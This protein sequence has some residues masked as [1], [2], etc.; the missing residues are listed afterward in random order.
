[1]KATTKKILTAAGILSGIAAAA[2]ASAYVTAKLFAETA[3]DREQPKV[4]KKAGKLISGG[5]DG[6]EFDEECAEASLRLQNKPHETVE[7]TASDGCRLLGHFYPVENPERVIIRFTAGA[8]PG[9]RISAPCRISG[10]KTDAVFCML[11]SAVKTAA[12]AAI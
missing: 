9:T 6:G 12:A 8:L 2:A 10:R 3:L 5:G 7:I 1:M 11:N 4:M